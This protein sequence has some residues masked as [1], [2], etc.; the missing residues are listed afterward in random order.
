MRADRADSGAEAEGAGRGGQ[1]F[2]GVHV[3]FGTDRA[4]A[5]TAVGPETE[6]LRRAYLDLL[7]LCLCDLAGPRVRAVFLA[8]D[9]GDSTK[10]AY[11]RELDE[12]ELGLRVEGVDW[13]YNGLTMVGLR[14]L[15]DLQE[16]VETVIAEE[17][18]GDL[19][20]TG[21]WRGGAAM[22][23][24]ATLDSLGAFSRTL[25]VADSFQGLPAPDDAFPEDRDLDLS[26]VDYLAVAE[27]EV[28]GNFER[29][30]LSEGVEFVPGFF[31]QTLPALSDR[32][33]ALIRLDG[34]TYEATWVALESLYPGLAP[35]GFAVIDDYGM[36]EECAAAV[37]EFRRRHGISSPVERVDGACVR[38]RKGAEEPSLSRQRSRKTKTPGAVRIDRRRHEPIP[39]ER[40]RE[41][42]L[43]LAKL[44][45]REQRLA[46]QPGKLAGSSWLRRPRTWLKRLRSVR[47]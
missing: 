2:R 19:I 37:D 6:T 28:R 17:V 24:R 1:S 45:D 10:Q 22:M 5:A 25:L 46:G 11:V 20:E 31:E 33:F 35:G 14:R 27:D 18:P 12:G 23:M 9:D 3:G 7:K 13:P 26:G 44:R 4:I 15:N 47:R 41:L 43:E 42:Q 21:T 29:F 38:W 32:S 36:I 40:E 34:D 8:D 16:C 39:T 30:G